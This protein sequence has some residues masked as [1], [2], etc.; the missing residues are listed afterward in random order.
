MRRLVWVI[1][2]ALSA[3]GAEKNHR[4][5]DDRDP[6]QRSARALMEDIMPHSSA[7]DEM[8][9]ISDPQRHAIWG[10][11]FGHDQIG[12]LVALPSPADKAGSDARLCLLLWKDGWKFAQWAGKVSA[13]IDHEQRWNWGVKRQVPNGGYYVIDSFDPNSISYREHL[14]WFCDPQTHSLRPTGWPKD[15]LASISGKTITFQRSVKSGYAP[16][17]FEVDEFD[18]KPG[19]NI[20]TF[21][22]TYEEGHR[23]LIT[24]RLPN[25]TIRKR[26]TWRIAE[27]QKPSEAYHN[28]ISLCRSLTEGELEPF[29]ED[30]TLDVQWKVGQSP[31]DA[32]SFL[33]WRLTGLERPAQYGQWDEDILRE[34]EAGY[35]NL[36]ITK[37]EKAVVVGTPEAVKAFSW[38]PR[39]VDGKP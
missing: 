1:L 29:H 22:T 36:D 20:A 2:L 10:P 31:T 37:P 14:S 15:A 39:E 11:I 33:I 27:A 26:V 30:A 6:K 21:S 5:S 25:P 12:A 38:P 9:K 19:G 24:V 13:S 23:A 3:R 18:G 17:I 35:V 32:P 16:T 28:R 8:A 34:R 7:S 4:Q